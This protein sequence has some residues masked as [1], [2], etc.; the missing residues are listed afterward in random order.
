MSH[1]PTITYLPWSETRQEQRLFRLTLGITLSLFL[2]SSLSVSFIIPPPAI[3]RDKLEEIPPRL[4]KILLDRKEKEQE[5][6]K[7]KPTEVKLEEVIIKPE[8]KI[9][10]EKPTPVE[11]KK[12]PVSKSQIKKPSEQELEAARKKAAQS[13]VLAMQD[14]L[15]SMRDIASFDTFSNPGALKSGNQGSEQSTADDLITRKAF[16]GSGGIQTSTVSRKT[17]DKLA[18]RTGST[19]TGPANNVAMGG[20]GGNGSSGIRQRTSE[21]IGLVF[22][23]H[24][25]SFY[26]LYRRALRT[27]LGLQGRVVFQ[28][29]IAPNGKVTGATIKSSELGDKKL[30]RKLLAKVR[31]IDF[32]AKKVEEWQGNYAIDF[33]PS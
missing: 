13:G 23:R 33:F 31:S 10:E 8:K 32:G 22:D 30:E 27:E 4:A 18:G 29:A 21:E 25:S 26:A 15:A 5:K 17:G 3:D 1:A 9:E 24:K 28:L 6:E 14:E 20:G 19:V 2:I 7:P 11:E 12:Q 16:S